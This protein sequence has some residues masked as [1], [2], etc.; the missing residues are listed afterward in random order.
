M[1]EDK[2]DYRVCITYYVTYSTR[3]VLVR[4][5]VFIDST[6]TIMCLSTIVQLNIDNTQC[7]LHM[8]KCTRHKRQWTIFFYI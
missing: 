2:M 8:A 7:V 1:T 4:S 6:T 5:N 3:R